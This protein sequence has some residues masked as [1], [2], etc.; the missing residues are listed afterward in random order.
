MRNR[1]LAFGIVLIIA[2]CG[3]KG[4]NPI[5]QITIGKVE[6]LTP[7]LNQPCAT[8]A[9]ISD[10]QSSVPFTWKAAD[11]AD[12]YD[13]TIKN[14]L[15]GALVTQS[16]TKAEITIS[17]TRN[18]PY[19]WFVTAKSAQPS[20][21]V[22]SDTWKFYNPGPG[23]VSYVPFPAEITAPIYGALIS[24]AT[25]D[26]KWKGSSAGNNIKFYGVYFGTTPA[27]P[28]MKSD[29]TDSFLNGVAIT[30]GTTY[31]WRVVT[32]DTNFNYSDSGLYQFTTK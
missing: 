18:V 2:G 28:L 9:V 17:L 19:S 23:T 16:A 31:Y 12:S 22:K 24:G 11:N 27:P 5:P 6:L 20:T 21:P 3:G 4:G 29:I 8:T 15:S 25:V 10:T 13:V 32:V 30:A 14:L 7:E 1:L 26:L